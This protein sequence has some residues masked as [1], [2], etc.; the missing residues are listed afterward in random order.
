MIS[1]PAPVISVVIPAWN[2]SA[3]LPRLIDSVDTART[4]YRGGSDRIEVILADNASTDDTAKIASSRGHHVVPVNQRCISAVRNGGAAVATGELLAFV[5]ADFRIDPETFNFIADVM[6]RAGIVGGATGVVF[7]RWSLGIRMSW[8]LILTPMWMLGLD[9]GVW[10]CRRSDFVSLGGFDERFRTGE[11]VRFLMALKRQGRMRN[12]REQ[13]IT[14]FTARR[15]SLKPALAAESTRKFE[16][17]GD[18]HL[19]REVLRNLPLRL[20]GR[21]APDQYV[22]RYWYQGRGPG[23]PR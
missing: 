21:R 13:L 19:F 22:E 5:N 8:L 15:F 14:R 12:P 10:F 3:Y 20:F 4:R 11:D 7:E 2:E 18:W 9:G 6:G 16:R 17:Y 1:E 23:S